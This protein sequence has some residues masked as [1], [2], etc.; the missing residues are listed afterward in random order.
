L[1]FFHHPHV[2]HCAL[3]YV[4]P[5]VPAAPEQ[6]AVTDTSKTF[7]SLSWSPP[8]SDGGSPVTGYHVERCLT[9]TSRW[10]RV[11]K[12][13]TTT[14]TDKEVVEDTE[15]QFRVCA[16]NKVGVGP[17]SEPT[18]PVTAKDPW[19]ES[20]Y[21]WLNCVMILRLECIYAFFIICFVI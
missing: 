13:E 18:D 4:F 7:I 10:I 9:T 12:S 6:L 2:L 16:E 8:S 21:S 11:G 14:Y 15:Y 19:S 3:L 17:P 1:S 5:D 20:A